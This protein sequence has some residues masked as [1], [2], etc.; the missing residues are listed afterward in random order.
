MNPS[1]GGRMKRFYLRDT[2]QQSIINGKPEGA[3]LKVPPSP[4]VW[5]NRREHAQS[6][7]AE[8]IEA[9]K[10]QWHYL[11]GCELIPADCKGSR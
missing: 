8:E 4:A 5:V 1:E 3:W 10:Q 7:S 11:N 6:F 9:L 2:R